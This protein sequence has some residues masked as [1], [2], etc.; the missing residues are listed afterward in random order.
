[1]A[2][3]ACAMTLQQAG[4]PFLLFEQDEKVGGRVQTDEFDGYRLDRGFQVLLTAYPEARKFLDYE[5]LELRKC[6]PGSR[7]WYKDKF[8]QVS[9]PFRHPLDGVCSVFNPIGSFWDKVKVGMLR[10]GLLSTRAMEDTLSTTEAL[11]EL[12][13]SEAMIDRFWKPFMRGVFL[14]NE[15]STSVRKFEETFSLFA[16]GDTVLPRL[17]IGEIPKQMAKRLPEDSIFLKQEVKKVGECSLVT[18]D[19]KEWQGRAVVLATEEPVANRLL[20]L[21][22]PNREWNSVDCLYFSLPEKEL[23][24]TSPILHLDGSGTGPINNLTFISTLSDC[25]PTGRAL[26]SASVIGKKEMGIDQVVELANQQ[27]SSWFGERAKKW[28]FLRAYRIR[29]AVPNCDCVPDLETKKNG[30]Y[31]CGDYLG[32]PSIDSAM[33]SGRLVAESIIAS[34]QG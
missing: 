1:M 22:Q 32:L 23:P 2:G 11:A 29:H 25:A 7:V 8:H 13:Y 28:D 16:K 26:A 10:L 3:L 33:R 18:S 24:C 21:K 19:G 9:D 14:E 17:G 12:G 6:Y 5:K 27:L 30:V 15:L 20:R 34:N 31:R 4:V